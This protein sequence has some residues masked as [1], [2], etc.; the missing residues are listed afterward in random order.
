MY[1]KIYALWQSPVV[2]RICQ[3]ILPYR[4]WII[5]AVHL[6]LFVFGY[7]ASFLLL[8]NGILTVQAEEL[9]YRTL[10]PL[11]II[12]TALFWRY[13]LYQGL[14]RYVSFPDLLN[15]VRATTLSSLTFL[16]IGMLWK[17]MKIPVSIYILDWAAC[18]LLVGGIRFVVRNFR[19]NL[20]PANAGQKA[21]NVLLVGPA[22][23]IQ[24]L[25]KEFISDPRSHY[26]PVAIID[27]TEKDASFQA[28]ISDVPVMSIRQSLKRQSSLSGVKTTVFCWPGAT[29]KQFDGVVEALRPLRTSFK[30]IPSVDELLS[31]NISISDLRD[32]EIEDLLERPPVQIEMDKIRAYLRG[33]TVLVT[34]AAGSIGSELC[35]QVASFKPEL[36]V[37]IERAEN[38]LYDLQLELHRDFPHVP[39][40]SRISSINDYSGMCAIFK[41]TKADVVFHAAAYKHV[42]LMEMTPIE[43]AYNNILGTYNVAKASL[44]AGVKRFV[45]ISTDKAVNPTN[46]MGVTK[47]IAEMVVQSFNGSTQTRFIT[48]RFGNV[49]GSAGS[50]IPIFKKQI[51]QGGPVT[52][53]DREIERFFMTI[54]ESVQLI[55]QSGCM[56]VGGEI[57]VLDMGKPVK[58]LSLAEKL[59]TLSGKWPHDDIEI[60]F[61]GLRPGEK[62][63]EE[64]F[65]KEE[66]HMATDHPRI[67][68][69]LS[70][71]VDTESMEKEIEQI[72]QLI[73]ERDEE[74][75]RNKFKELVPGYQFEP[76]MMHSGN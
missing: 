3:C 38:S 46:I 26:N 55:L 44:E 68:V 5:L 10:F 21:V 64:L 24:L 53:T 35:R 16:V 33:K 17:S 29:K 57:F 59:I 50:V 23:R 32:V 19:E 47:H 56:G 20:L 73:K 45:M 62:M 11:L 9:L 51:A 18:I 40:C 15:I 6:L 27:P 58:I 39:L 31:G 28:R 48:V 70:E 60:T 71:S 49:L 37:L 22:A 74:A 43:S 34:G 65:N 67:M 41:E 42:P 30:T 14:W 36:L 52:V 66:Q 13:D 1:E 72:H 63:Y 61:E 8:N 76:A 25:L 69:A 4:L 75:L 7:V 12:R 2:R 54:Q